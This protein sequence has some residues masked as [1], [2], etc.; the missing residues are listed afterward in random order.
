MISYD[1]S[2]LTL[3][4]IRKILNASKSYVGEKLKPYHIHVIRNTTFE[5]LVPYLEAACLGIGVDCSIS[6]SSYDVVHN[7]SELHG[8][9]EADI[10]IV[11]L[12]LEALVP[13]FIES[14]MSLSV[15]EADSIQ[16]HIVKNVLDLMSTL[17]RVV[18]QPVLINSFSISPQAGQGILLDQN[19]LSLSNRI[20]GIN[21]ALL[22]IFQ[23]NDS[24]YVVDIER[25]KSKIG[26][27]NFVDRRH[28][29]LHMVPYSSRAFKELAME[30]RKYI[31]VMIGKS[32]RFLVL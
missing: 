29:H 12:E 5:P 24:V 32:K 23:E 8:V 21:E 20:R 28:W 15:D 31:A 22:K 30:Y 13:D 6:F 27:M 2:K 16:S 26:H 7:H 11:A 18:G 3:S 14:F 10:Y 17:N 19:C 9:P 4:Q 25:M 1:I